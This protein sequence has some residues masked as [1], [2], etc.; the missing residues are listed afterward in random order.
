[1]L[2][3][4]SLRT[5]VAPVFESLS[6]PLEEEEEEEEEEKEGEKEKEK[7]LRGTI[8]HITHVHAMQ[9]LVW[10]YCKIHKVKFPHSHV[11]LIIRSQLTL[12]Y[13]YSKYCV[14]P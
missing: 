7:K 12:F 5:P 1:M 14:R 4:S 2:A 9:C 10:S 6:E 11:L 13:C 3:A 8:K